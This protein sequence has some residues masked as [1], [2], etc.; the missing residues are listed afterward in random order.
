MS[1][2]FAAGEAMT[3]DECESFVDCVLKIGWEM[4]RNGA[5]VRR[6]EDTMLRISEAYGFTVSSSYASTTQVELS[7]V[8]P[9]GMHFTQA[10]RI[11]RT[12]NDLGRVEALNADARRI[13]QD[14]PPVSE[15]PDTV[16]KPSSSKL[17]KV[18]GFFA[19]PVSAFAFAM[20][21]GG[22][23]MDGLGSA[24]V[25]I[26]IYLMDHFFH[27]RRYNY[28]VYT[29]VACFI[30]S[31]LAEVCFKLGIG[32]N[33]DMLMSGDVMIFIPGLAMVNGIKEMIYRDI[34]T[35]IFRIMEAFLVAVA[36]AV[37]YALGILLFAM[38]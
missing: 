36:I 28:I 4:V 17:Q 38:L 6:A 21:F 26:F 13:C 23:V 2:F 10:M 9:E 14:K 24:L 34:I 3:R 33:I 1:S 7:L 37:G 8:S 19:Y 18:L 11:E 31:C 22:S 29:V 27:L 35:G 16:S 20:F 15:L 5:E 32:D 25:A 12:W 30:A